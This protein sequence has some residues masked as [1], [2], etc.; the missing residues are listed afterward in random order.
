MHVLCG[1]E[2]SRQRTASLL[3]QHPDLVAAQ[4]LAK[5]APLLRQMPWL[6]VT[7]V[8]V[9][10]LGVFRAGRLWGREGGR[11]EDTQGKQ[12]NAWFGTGRLVQHMSVRRGARV[13]S[14]AS[15]VRYTDTGVPAPRGAPNRVE[16]TGQRSTPHSEEGAEPLGLLVGVGW[17]PAS[18]GGRNPQKFWSA[19][20]R[21]TGWFAA[22]C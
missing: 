6:P 8:D 12:S 14:R 1:Q 21:A 11:R 18:T 7:E 9:R 16:A 22:P 20:T 5:A 4:W 3:A 19:T 13:N 2:R 17:L 10:N 15:V